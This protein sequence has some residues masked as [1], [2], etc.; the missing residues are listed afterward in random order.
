MPRSWVSQIIRDKDHLMSTSQYQV[1]PG[2]LTFGKI[3]VFAK[4][5][6]V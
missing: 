2:V 3:T 1:V 5:Y 6:P 4:R